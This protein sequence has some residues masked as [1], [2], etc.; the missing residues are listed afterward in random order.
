AGFGGLAGLHLAAREFPEACELLALRP[1]ADQ[2][3]AVGVHKRGG[4]D[5]QQGFVGHGGFIPALSPKGNTPATNSTVQV[6]INAA[7]PDVPLAP[8]WRYRRSSRVG[9]RFEAQP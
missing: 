2:H 7:N 5:Q 3:P 8:S 6:D 4:G 9:P 1:L